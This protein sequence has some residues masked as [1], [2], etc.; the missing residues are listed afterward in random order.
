MSG[1]VSSAASRPLES[2]E[3]VACGLRPEANFVDLGALVAFVVLAA[4]IS[5]A[6]R[7]R[8]RLRA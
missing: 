4:W 3:I 6:R 2:L 1:P 8:A 5:R 7:V